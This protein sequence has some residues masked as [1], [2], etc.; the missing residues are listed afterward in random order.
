MGVN[1]KVEDCESILFYI[2]VNT[3]C[4]VHEYQYH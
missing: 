4:V 3:K 1:L 2:A